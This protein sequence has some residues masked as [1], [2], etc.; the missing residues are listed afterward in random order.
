[1]SIVRSIGF[2]ENKK[3]NDFVADSTTRSSFAVIGYSFKM[4][5]TSRKHSKRNTRD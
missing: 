4:T 3:R 2:P 5:V 1:M